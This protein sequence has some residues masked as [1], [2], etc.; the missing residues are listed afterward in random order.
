MKYPDVSRRTRAFT[1]IELLVVIAIIA[2]LAAILF[3]VFAQAREAARRTTCLS[4]EKQVSLAVLQYVQDYDESLPLIF[5]PNN[6]N[7]N[8]SMG[9]KVGWR[10]YTW[11]NLV[12]PYSKNW[13]AFTCPD[14]GMTKSDPATSIDPFSNFAML[15]RS[16][17]TNQPFFTDQFYAG[18]PVAYQGIGGAAP[19]TLGRSPIFGLELFP[20]A[21]SLT[22]S[23]VAAPTSV[24]LLAESP[25]PDAWTVTHALNITNTCEMRNGSIY[26][27]PYFADYGSQYYMGGPIA[28]HAINGSGSLG[29]YC[30]Q[31]QPGL[32]NA[33]MNVALL[34]GHAK[35]ME[36]RQFW[37]YRTTTAGQRVFAYMWPDEVLN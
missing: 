23:A 6:S 4:N 34:D 13:Q 33:I 19:D 8:T 37:S 3:P 29:K 25:Y 5:A 22:L 17:V 31:F 35:A 11:Q 14:S 24:T 7:D 9:Y 21:P 1:L 10:L 32:Q 2:I 16:A 26:A 36:H 28:R 12:Q 27:D 20:G 30:W 18:T 15:G